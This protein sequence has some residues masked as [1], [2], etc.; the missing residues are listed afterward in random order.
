M[1]TIVYHKGVIGSD[2]GISGDDI[3]LRTECKVSKIS[4]PTDIE[5]QCFIAGTGRADTVERLRAWFKAGAR[6]PLFPPVDPEDVSCLMAAYDGARQRVELYERG[7]RPIVFEGATFAM[8]TG[9]R[10]ALG[11]LHALDLMDVEPIHAVRMAM[12]A[13]GRY[14]VHTSTEFDINWFQEKADEG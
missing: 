8:G 7:P 13:A 9:E 14:D 1:T 10:Y 5:G 4:S 12:Q 3:M 6:A 11:A 2:R